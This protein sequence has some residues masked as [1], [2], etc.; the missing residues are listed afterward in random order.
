M[1]RLRPPPSNPDWRPPP[2]RPAASPENRPTY[3]P[4]PF[5]YRSTQYNEQSRVDRRNTYQT[6]EER[7]K[8]ILMRAAY[9]LLDEMGLLD[10]VRHRLRL[11]HQYEDPILQIWEQHVG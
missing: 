3:G 9:E 7:E 5:S 4:H 1:A 8:R 11:K 2:R 6:G 10:A